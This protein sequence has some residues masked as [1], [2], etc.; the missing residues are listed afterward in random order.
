MIQ[1]CLNIDLKFKDFQEF[2]PCSGGAA[3]KASV[4]CLPL[5]SRFRVHTIVDLTGSTIIVGF[6]LF[7][8]PNDHER[9]LL[10]YLSP[11]LKPID[12]VFGMSQFVHTSSF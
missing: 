5:T 9:Y 12:L 6:T 2:R 3:E 11:S 8:S 4:I 1:Q 10:L 7:D